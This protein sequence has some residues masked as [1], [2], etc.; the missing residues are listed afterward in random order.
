MEICTHN[1]YCGGCIYQEMPYSAQLAYKG[2]EVLRLLQEKGIDIG[3]LLTPENEETISPEKIIAPAPC[4]Y[5]YRNKMEYTFGNQVK[6]GEMTLGM[7]QKAV[8][9][10]L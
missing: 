3:D 9:C 6:G 5:R 1:E 2:S 7:H 10:R 8:S 4:I